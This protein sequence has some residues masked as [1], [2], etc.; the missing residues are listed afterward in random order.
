M[1]AREEAFGLEYIKSGGNA[2]QSA[3]LA[4]YSKNTAQ[5]AT[6]WITPDTERNSESNR[7]LPY[8]PYL[9][10]FID[11]ERE[12]LKSSKIADAQEILEYLTSVLRGESRSEIVVVE[13][14]G[15]GMSEARPFKKHPDEK[16][17]LKAGEQLS[18]ILGLS[19]EKLEMV[20]TQVILADDVPEDW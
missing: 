18:K 17:R 7:N 10:E 2:Y 9:R 19:R 11:S 8:K 12:K 16:E 20:Q 1:D 4:G 14:V 13:S 5:H 15:D 3:L 6:E